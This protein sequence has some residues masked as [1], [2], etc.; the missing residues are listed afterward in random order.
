VVIS[1][2]QDTTVPFIF[3]H[4][5]SPGTAVALFMPVL[6]NGANY[7]NIFLLESEY[8][9]L[10]DQPTTMKKACAVLF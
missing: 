4:F 7:D 10:A 9:L 3:L 1:L 5:S 2:A 8:G 6:S